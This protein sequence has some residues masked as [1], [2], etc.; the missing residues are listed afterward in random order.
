MASKTKQCLVVYNRVPKCASSTITWVINELHNQHNFAVL[1]HNWPM[2]KQN[3]NYD[4]K[5]RKNTDIIILSTYIKLLDGVKIE[6]IKIFQPKAR[7][8]IHPPFGLFR[9]G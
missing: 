1:N 5:V 3:L 8:N 2:I 4:E 9:H 7:L 6:Y